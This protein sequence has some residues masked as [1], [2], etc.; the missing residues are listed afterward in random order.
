MP[1]L[2][3]GRALALLV[4]CLAPVLA[5]ADVDARFARLR[6]GAEPLSSVGGFVDHYIGDCL[7]AA[8]GGGECARNAQAFRQAADGKKYYLII[9]EPSANQLQLSEMDAR[10]GTFILNVT[11]FLAGSS[12]AVTHGAPRGTDSAGNPIIPFLRVEGTLPEGWSPAMM[13]RQVQAQALRLQVV[14][15]PQGLWTLPRKGGGQ[16][17]GVKARFEG[18]LVSVGRTG[19]QIGLWLAR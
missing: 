11:P 6:D 13:A 18:V 15:T 12:S 7:S 14:F 4:V 9:T 3:A 5:W 2:R 1:R 8:L 19:E 17:K 16:L 10:T